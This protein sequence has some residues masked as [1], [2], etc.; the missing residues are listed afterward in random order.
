MGGQGALPLGAFGVF[1]ICP[2]IEESYQ[3]RLDFGRFR[4]LFGRFRAFP[5]VSI[6]SKGAGVAGIL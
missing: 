3:I 6:V 2:S 4:V 5:I 1:D